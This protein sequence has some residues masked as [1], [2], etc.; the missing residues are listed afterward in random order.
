MTDAFLLD[1]YQAFLENPTPENYRRARRITLAMPGFDRH[2]LA[3][4]E[5]SQLCDEGRFDEVLRRSDDM[6]T[7]WRLS[8]R[9]HLLVGYAASQFGDQEEVELSRFQFHTCLEALL[10]TGEGTE[11]SPYYVLRTCDQYDVIRA[12]GLRGRCQ[13]AAEHRG[14]SVDIVQCDGQIEVWFDLGPIP[15]KKRRSRRVS[16]WLDRT[17]S[18]VLHHF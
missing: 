8:P 15:L 4:V 12:L 1:A 6:W 9:Y 11:T 16:R 18:Q 14:R 5:L 2:S 10:G 13:C 3:W 17:A 7:A